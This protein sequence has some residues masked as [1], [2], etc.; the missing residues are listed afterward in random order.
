LAAEKGGPLWVGTDMSLFSLDATGAPQAGQL[1]PV[2]QVMAVKVD[3]LLAGKDGG[4]WR[5]TGG[6]VQFWRAN[7]QERHFGPYPWRADALVGAACEDAK[8]NL[9]VGTLGDGIFW[10]DENGNYTHITKAQG[11]SSDWALSLCMDREGSLWVGTDGDGLNRV[12]RSSFTTAAAS[13]GRVVKSVCED[14][15]G[16]LWVGYNGGAAYLKE[17]STQEFGAANG[18]LN[19]E[20]WA[21]FV[22][23]SRRVWAGTSGGLYTFDAE[24]SQF[25][26]CNGPNELQQRVLAIHQDRGGRLWFG[27]QNGLV[28][29]DE[30]E[31]KTYTRTSGLSADVVRAIVDDAEGNIWIGTMG[32]GLNCLARDKF[33]SYRKTDNGLPSDDIS[34]LHVDKEG[35]LWIGTFGSGL[36]RLHKGRWTRYSTRDGL[37]SNAL[38]YLVE[39]GEGFLWMGSTAGLMR[40]AKLALN[41]FADGT[42][43]AIF[44]R[45]YGAPDGVSECTQGSQPG[46]W[47][48]R[49][50]KLWFPTTKGLYS[51]G[52]NH[53]KRNPNPPPVV[54]E[55]VLVEG[56]AQTTDAL[57]SA[58]PSRIV[59]PPQR[60][61]LEIHYTSLNLAAAKR[62]RFSYR[63]EGYET[64]PTDAGYSRVARYPKLPPGDY[65]FRVTARNEDGI[66]STTGSA[67]AITVL[68]PFWQTWWF[69]TIFVAFLLGVV[70]AVVYVVSTKKLQRQLERLQQ[71]EAI[72]RDRARIAR[73][74]HD[75][76]GASLTQVALLGELVE[77]D[78]ELPTEVEA[79]GR[80]IAQTARETTHVVDE[81]VWAVNPSNDTLDS[82]VTYVCKYA[83]DYLTL[84]GLRYR[85]DVPTQ[86]PGTPVAPEVRHNVYLSVKE[87]VTNVVRHAQ[88][89]EVWIRMRLED[90]G[91]SLEI[92]DNGRGVDL[93][94]PQ[95]RN[96]LRNMRKRMEDVGGQFSI[97]AAPEGGTRVMLTVPI[98]RS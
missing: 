41:E 46:A 40:V 94:K 54:I 21:V 25:F 70:V 37:L 14:E 16:G 20:V 17:G 66:G 30:R 87:A 91:F 9:V 12:R 33:S 64:S 71:Q 45:L 15:R 1:P 27:T 3:Y 44:C 69:R 10:Y 59:V 92:Q 47:R 97:G 31:W 90:A 80:Q 51:L 52:P 63:M 84:A 53:L 18:L 43:N 49:D 72:E 8:G 57:R 32:G 68:P 86:L 74:L 19:P 88:A 56:R 60:E 85:L 23:R 29:W 2:N 79:H 26:L 96:G 93:E 78:R 4:C 35:V 42:T 61:Q 22:D 81:I 65:T 73:D 13:R 48:A 11:L 95:T 77:S 39:D 7:K 67:L 83:Q 89:S 58:Q 55:S 36:A 28:C 24:R 75:Q 34:S 38:G 6:Q 82:L 98:K 62:A 50:G 76:L 5:L